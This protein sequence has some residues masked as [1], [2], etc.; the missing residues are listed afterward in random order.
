MLAIYSI[1]SSVLASVGTLFLGYLSVETL[2]AIKYYITYKSWPKSGLALEN[3]VLR[4]QAQTAHSRLA[5]QQ[6]E[7]TLLQDKITE[8]DKEQASILKRLIEGK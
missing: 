2:L 8:L 4:H 3:A 6:G 5:E 1:C 7:N